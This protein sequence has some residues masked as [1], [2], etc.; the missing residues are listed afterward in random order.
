MN[1]LTDK[2][3]WWNYLELVHRY[4]RNVSRKFEKDSS[5]RT[6]DIQRCPNFSKE[7]RQW[8]GWQT[9]KK[10]D[11]IW[12]L[13]TDIPGMFPE[14]L[15]KIAHLQLKISKDNLISVRKWGNE[16][17]KTYKKSEIIWS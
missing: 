12:N 3:K 11:T 13:C 2:Q 4:P 17:W 9:C 7:V 8:T 6:G 14:N 10:S 15:K 1:R 5:S 16:H